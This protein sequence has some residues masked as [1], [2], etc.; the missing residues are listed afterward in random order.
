MPRP[1]K[2]DGQDRAGRTRV[3]KRRQGMRLL[4]IWVPDPAAPG[5]RDEAKRQAAL[6]RGVPE[7]A[8]ALAF[9]ESAMEATGDYSAGGICGHRGDRDASVCDHPRQPC[10]LPTMQSRVPGTAVCS[11][12]C[13]RAKLRYSGVRPSRS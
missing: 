5:F 8:A 3:N 7:A 12:W 4:R 9:I 13:V 6:L 10:R 2:Q 11:V 1:A